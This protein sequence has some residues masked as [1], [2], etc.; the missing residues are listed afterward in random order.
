MYNL[1]NL[2]NLYKYEL[3]IA[4][5]VHVKIGPIPSPLLYCIFVHR[6][7]FNNVYNNVYSIAVQ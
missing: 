4:H 5:K 7:V 6:I 1:Y 3:N 2:Y